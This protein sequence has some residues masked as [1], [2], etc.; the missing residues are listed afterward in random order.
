M[1]DSNQFFE[2]FLSLSI[3]QHFFLLTKKI[4]KARKIDFNTYLEENHRYSVQKTIT[5]LL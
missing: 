5:E 4:A 3:S 2:Y 1:Q